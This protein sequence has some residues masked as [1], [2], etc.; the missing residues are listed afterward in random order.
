MP[1]F[2]LADYLKG[3]TNIGLMILKNIA[4]TDFTGEIPNKFFDY[5]SSG[6]PIFITWLDFRNN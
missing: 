1:K 5:I 3:S 2:L 4:Q 6:L